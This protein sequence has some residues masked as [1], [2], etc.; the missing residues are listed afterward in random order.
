VVAV[1]IRGLAARKLRTFLTALAV[2]LGVAMI[3]GTFI[4][5]DTINRSFDNVFSTALKGVDVSVTPREVFSNTDSGALPASLLEKVRSVSGVQ[6]AI[7]SVFD[8]A[9][10]VDKKGKLING[11]GAP[12]FIASADPAP[13]DPFNY[14]Q[15]RA[16]RTA[17][18]VA[19]DQHAANKAGFKLGDTVRVRGQA[20]ERGYRLVGISKFGDAGSLAGASVAILTLP[21]AQRTTGNVGRFDAIDVQ[22]ASGVDREVLSRRIKAV[23]GPSATVRTGQQE[24]SH[25]SSQ[26]KDQLSFLTTL[27]LVFGGIALFVGAFMIFNSFSITVAQRMREFAIVRMLG[28]S[29]RQVLWA[30]AGE[31]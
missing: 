7:G 16:P 9:R 13:F 12:S 29:R 26:I 15:G 14:V 17:G 2:V 19:L 11:H 31:A 10:I 6:N 5:T 8:Q 4:F 22:G 28:G 20:P 3:A 25:S 23:V 27:L 1:T 21:E 18:E 24:A 30:V